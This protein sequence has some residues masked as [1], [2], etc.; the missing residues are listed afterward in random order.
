MSKSNWVFS[1]EIKLGMRVANVKLYHSIEDLH[2]LER[3]N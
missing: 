1:L 3:M 2:L